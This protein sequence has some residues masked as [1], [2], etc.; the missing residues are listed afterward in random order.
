MHLQEGDFY[1]H[2]Q[3]DWNGIKKYNIAHTDL[4]PM[5][6]YREAIDEND[7][8]PDYSS[9][10]KVYWDHHFEVEMDEEEAMQTRY[11]LYFRKIDSYIKDREDQIVFD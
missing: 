5:D 6:A 7:P 10:H 1:L 3:I 11:C 2:E 9:Y 8:D 4:D